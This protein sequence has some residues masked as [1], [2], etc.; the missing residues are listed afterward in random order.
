MA[1]AG[2]KGMYE[3]NCCCSDVSFR[4]NDHARVEYS[5]RK[6]WRMDGWRNPAR[7]SAEKSEFRQ[8]VVDPKNW[9]VWIKPNTV[10]INRGWLKF[11]PD[12]HSNKQLRRHFE[13]FSQCLRLGLAYSTLAID[14]LRNTPTRSED[15]HHVCLAK[16]ILFHQKL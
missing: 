3:D 1:K 7:C 11:C 14:Y 15:R 12:A 4:G 9:T 6:G 8:S 10:T 13:E 16:I 5:S 2:D